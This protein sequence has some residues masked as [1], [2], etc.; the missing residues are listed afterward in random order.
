MAFDRFFGYVHD[1]GTT[2][3][4]NWETWS[5]KSKEGAKGKCLIHIYVSRSIYLEL[6]SFFCG[7]VVNAFISPFSVLFFYRKLYFFLYPL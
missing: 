6:I 3:E 5:S 1:D 7:Y 4:G 2:H